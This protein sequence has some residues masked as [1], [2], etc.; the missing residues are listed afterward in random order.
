MIL[1][2]LPVFFPVVQALDFGMFPDEV[3]IWFGILVIIVVGIGLTA[4]PVGLNVFVISALARDIPMTA[5]YRGVLPFIV[6]DIVRL[7]LVLAFPG[8]AL[9]LVRLLQ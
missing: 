5:T 7:C 6:A 2:T 8:L 1:L 3:A 9:W 4:P